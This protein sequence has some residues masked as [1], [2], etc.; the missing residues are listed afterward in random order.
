[1]Q[2]LGELSS[3]YRKVREAEEVLDFS[4]HAFEMRVCAFEAALV[5]IAK[6]EGMLRATQV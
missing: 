4:L 2:A 1:M 3:E 6:L 5:R